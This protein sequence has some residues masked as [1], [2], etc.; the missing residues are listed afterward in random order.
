M[1]FTNPGAWKCFWTYRLTLVAFS[2]LLF[3]MNF[4]I[5]VQSDSWKKLAKSVLF[6]VCCEHLV[7][8][9]GLK[10][11]LSGNKVELRVSP[12]HLDSS[13][14]SAIPAT[15]RKVF[16]S[17]EEG[18]C[19]QEGTKQVCIQQNEPL[20]FPLSKG[21][22]GH[23]GWVQRQQGGRDALSHTAGGWVLCWGHPLSHVNEWPQLQAAAGDRSS[24]EGP[25]QQ[26]IPED[27]RAFQQP[28][29]LC[30]SS[31]SC[32]HWAS[33]E[34]LCRSLSPAQGWAP[35]STAWEWRKGQMN[36][37]R[38]G[39]VRFGWCCIK[40]SI[41]LCIKI[42]INHTLQFQQRNSPKMSWFHELN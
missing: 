5:W 38:P 13:K 9:L 24:Q 29:A 42:F 3:Y 18:F 8:C 10:F 4:S 41:Y 31:L 23:V 6:K 11:H 19:P 2:H 26:E 20:K 22:K 35:G 32:T 36:E 14:Y 17:W 25:N 16:N 30:C 27:Y 37:M 21:R 1:V 34:T 15:S 33:E 39:L 40:S 12:I 7:I 28:N